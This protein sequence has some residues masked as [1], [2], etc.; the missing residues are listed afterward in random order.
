VT[1]IRQESMR[2]LSFDPLRSLGAPGVTHLKPDQLFERR[3]ELR[4]ADWVLF[5]EYWQVN[6]LVYGL[7]RR[8][9][10]SVNSYHLGHDK[11]EMTRAFLSVAPEHVPATIIR[12]GGDGAFDAVLEGLGLPVVLKEIRNAQGRGVHRVDTRP[13]LREWVET[14]DVVYAQEVLPI[15]RDLRV[16]WVGDRVL[17]AYWRVAE[18][19]TFH[20]NVARGGRISFEDVP[21]AALALVERVARGLGIDHAGFDVAMVDGH[22]WLL[23]F[24]TFF[25]TEALR[26]AGIRPMEA[27]LA[28]LEQCHGTRPEEPSPGLTPRG[29]GRPARRAA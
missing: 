2:L 17:T 14:I 6:A 23:E 4:D 28:W 21:P 8:I 27:I 18:A 3:A 9:F 24:N 12:P 13:P 5:P 15:D 1:F 16:V 19:G 11:V 25:G 20:N 10:P 7:H 29:G 22:P 26:T